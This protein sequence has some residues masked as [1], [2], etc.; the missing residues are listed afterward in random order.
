[1][2]VE[3]RPTI[4]PLKDFCLVC[5]LILDSTIVTRVRIIRRRII[6]SIYSLICLLDLSLEH[7]IGLIKSI[8]D[9]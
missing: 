2:L 9:Y 6:I 1:M 5:G 3:L 8:L 7:L 4:L